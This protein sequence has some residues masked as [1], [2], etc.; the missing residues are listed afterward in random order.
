MTIN[1]KPTLNIDVAEFEHFLNGSDATEAEKQEYLELVWNIVCEFAMIGFYIHPV[2]QAREAC[3][4]HDETSMPPVNA[5][6]DPA[7]SG[8]RELI[9]AFVDA[10][11]DEDSKGDAHD[12]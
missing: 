11:G 6:C 10:F 4:K 7:E 3:G 5:T 2:Q 9:A 12:A 1:K 8:N